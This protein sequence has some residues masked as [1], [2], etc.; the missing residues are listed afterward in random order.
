M[1]QGQSGSGVDQGQH[2]VDDVMRPGDSSLDSL[3]E[4]SYGSDSGKLSGRH[5]SR[6]ALILAAISIV[7]IGL[8]GAAAYLLSGSHKNQDNN[9]VGSANV[10]HLSISDL[11]GYDQLAKGLAQNLQ[12]NGKLSVG[13]AFVL[14]PSSVPNQPSLGQLYFD[15]QTNQPYYYNGNQFVSLQPVVG[16]TIA[17]ASSPV[18]L[19]QG[20]SLQGTT[21]TNTGVTSLSGTANQVTVSGSTGN[22]R[23]SL[24]T[25]LS[26]AGNFSAATISGNGSGL[27]NLPASALPSDVAY[28]DHADQT[29]TGRR[30]HFQNSANDTNAFSVQDASGNTLLSVDSLHHRITTTDLAPTVSGSSTLGVYQAAGDVPD[31]GPVLIDGQNRAGRNT[32]AMVLG[33]D[34][35]ARIAYDNYDSV[36]GQSSLLF[37]RCLDARCSNPVIT[38]V[39]SVNGTGGFNYATMVM[40]SDGFARIAYSG[41]DGLHLVICNDQDC[42]SSTDQH[43]DGINGNTG[44]YGIG[45]DI[46]ANGLVRLAYA[47]NPSGW[48]TFYAACND[49]DCTAPTIQAIDTNFWGYQVASLALGP[50]GFA[51]IAYEDNNNAAGDTYAFKLARC[52]DSACTSPVITV[53]QNDPTSSQYPGCQGNVVKIGSDGLPRLLY[54]DCGNNNDGSLHFVQ[55]LDAD[56]TQNNQQTLENAQES[57]QAM[58]MTLAPDNTARILYDDY[59]NGYLQ[60]DH[61]A[62]AGCSS[63]TTSQIDATLN[64]GDS[65]LGAVVGSD[66]L[67]RIAYGDDGT[68]GVKYARIKTQVGINQPGQFNQGTSIGSASQ[69][70]GQI[71]AQNINLQTASTA[72]ALTVD[73]EGILTQTSAGQAIVQGPIAQFQLNGSTVAQF[74]QNGTFIE[75]GQSGGTTDLADFQV[76]AVTHARITNAGTLTLQSVAGQTTD[77]QDWTDVSG[78]VYAKV[79]SNGSLTLQSVSGQ[80]TDLQDWNAG[81]GDVR[82]R[83]DWTGA[84]ILAS[85]TQGADLQDW[86]DS[87]GNLHG[88][89]DTN[90]TL[91]LQAVTGQTADLQDWTDSSGN[92]HGKVDSNGTLTL[93]SVSGQ[94]ADLQDWTDSSGNVLDKVDAGGGLAMASASISGSLTVSTGGGLSTVNAG[95]NFIPDPTFAGI[96]PGRGSGTYQLVTG[97][98]TA[99]GRALKITPANDITTDNQNCALSGSGT[100]TMSFLAWTDSGTEPIWLLEGPGNEFGSVTATTTKQRFSVTFTHGSYCNSFE[101]GPNGGTNAVYI[102]DWQVESGPTGTPF[103][104]G[105]EGNGYAWTGTPNNSSSTRAQGI[106]LGGDLYAAGNLAV[107]TA[108]INGTLTV[109]GHII[110]GGSTPTIAAG[111]G[112]GTGPTV[113]ISGNDTSGTIT[114]TTGTSPTAGTL[115]TVTFGS[116]YG[117]A[118]RVTF[119]PDN[120]S[121]ATVQYYAGS[122]TSTLTLDSNNAPAASTTYTYFYHAEQ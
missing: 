23:L 74:D 58:Q 47:N 103:I 100:Y 69:R 60:L 61:C 116:T 73:Q 43:I 86:T 45:L 80:I 99:T 66:G 75:N 91:T 52:T 33:F 55:C 93:Q 92:L 82:D 46:T 8:I 96:T 83:V 71:T 1:Q 27:T 41:N 44:S 9:A 95:T 38:T 111:T 5:L 77:L 42:S 94:T 7:V 102:A 97:Q 50:D 21:L 53:V 15:A 78:N 34:G 39:E 106:Y 25:N 36:A 85:G 54:Q 87:S 68:T 114:I 98:P 51:R 76:N 88:K 107:K 105:D 121:A 56:C 12:V 89:V 112:A 57:W 40:G 30:Q 110:T 67:L 65:G 63:H 118:P 109:N 35:F 70:F 79:K 6:M 29:I 101:I 115:A 117:S 48:Q 72:S 37:A 104:Y 31:I 17:G 120:G 22:V 113:S 81:N 108:T 16:G 49:A 90:G 28:T 32:T 122:T 11:T 3:P 119:T 26:I 24:P 4:Q 2:L 59:T 14:I 18:T 13:G 64:A 20:L 62:D 19:A 84:L 10:Q